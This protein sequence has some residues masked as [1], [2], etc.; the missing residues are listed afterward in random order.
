MEYVF[1]EGV[2]SLNAWNGMCW[3]I[4]E[5]DNSKHS[6]LF[7]V[8]KSSIFKELSGV[9]I[10][11]TGISKAKKRMDDRW[12]PTQ[13]FVLFTSKSFWTHKFYL[14]F[15]PM[16]QFIS[17]ATD[18]I[19]VTSPPQIDQFEWWLPISQILSVSISAKQQKKHNSPTPTHHDLCRPL[20]GQWCHGMLTQSRR[21]PGRVFHVIW[22]FETP[23]KTNK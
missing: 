3:T 9:K 21:S 10:W 12:V 6:Q 14:F 11:E 4:R 23:E 15:F 22:G 17:E 7:V 18:K 20:P 19:C 5:P 16:F 8:L 2:S 13:K 1:T